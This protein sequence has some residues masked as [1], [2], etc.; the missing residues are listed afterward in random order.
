MDCVRVEVIKVLERRPTGEPTK[1][2][3]VASVWCPV[4]YDRKTV[5][6]RWKGDHLSPTW[7]F[8][9]RVD[10]CDPVG[11]VSIPKGCERRLS[12]TETT[13]DILKEEATEDRRQK[14]S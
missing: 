8:V 6:A 9:F 7:D 11:Q 14:D 3:L 13:K 4:D 1:D 10:K 2:D 5:L 12:L